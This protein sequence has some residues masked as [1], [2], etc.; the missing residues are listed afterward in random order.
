MGQL[1]GV[2]GVEG[3]VGDAMKWLD[4]IFWPIIC[5]FLRK[6]AYRD[7]H[8]KNQFFGHFFLFWS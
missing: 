1:S 4:I 6:M 7:Q 8:H 5:I 3:I 2:M